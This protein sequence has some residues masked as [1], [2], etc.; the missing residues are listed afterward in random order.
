MNIPLQRMIDGIIATMRSDVIPHVAD[1]YARGQAVGV[2][3]LLNNI[4][5]RV[6][7]AQAPLAR[8]IEEKRAL[9]A[10][11]AEVVP[12]ALPDTADAQAA[13]AEELLLAKGMLDAAIGDAIA[14]IWPRRHEPDF[15]RAAAL[16]QAHLH[17][18]MAAEMKITRKPLFAEIASGGDGAKV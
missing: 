9:L 7:W 3:D 16:V 11:I 1:S 2:I 18:E 8:Q 12:G 5:P 14:A 15:A 13:T 17:D 4:A 10:G 6:E